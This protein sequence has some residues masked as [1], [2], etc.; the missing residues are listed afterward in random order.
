VWRAHSAG[1]FPNEFWDTSGS[2]PRVRIPVADL[3]SAG[4]TIGGSRATRPV[5]GLR[6][7]TARQHLGN[8]GAVVEWAMARGHLTHNPTRAVTALDP[9]P[10]IAV[11]PPDTAPVRVLYF[12]ECARVAAHLSIHHQV[13]YWIGRCCGLRVGEVFGLHV[14]DID[15]AGFLHVS[16]QGGGPMERWGPDGSR[17]KVYE[18]GVKSAAGIRVVPMPQSL[19]ALVELY[20]RAWH[21]DPTTG[22]LDP[23]ARLI[24]PPQPGRGTG[25]SS[26]THALTNALHAESL[27]RHSIGFTNLTHHLRKSLGGDLTHYGNARGFQ[28]SRLLGHKLGADGG[29]QI[30]VDHYAPPNPDD[31][32]P[33][34]VAMDTIEGLIGDALPDGLL[35]GTDAHAIAGPQIGMP[36]QQAHA[37]EVIADALASRAPAEVCTVAAAAEL[38]EV[39]PKQVRRL[40]ALGTLES[41]DAR[42]ATGRPVLAVTRRSVEAYAAEQRESC[43]LLEA[44]ELTGIG[45]STLYERMRVGTLLTHRGPDGRTPWVAW[46]EVK[47]LVEE[48]ELRAAL[49]DRSLTIPAAARAIGRHSSTVER[50]LAVGKLEADESASWTG[51]TYVTRASLAA[52]QEARGKDPAK[53]WATRT[54]VARLRPPAPNGP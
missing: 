39:T 19:L 36:E 47:L 41:A 16:H 31:V 28:V 21:A 23:Q 50:L 3:V 48:V 38:L 11:T 43:T 26:Y 37:R 17:I 9:D 27:D 20:L 13:C 35:Q 33:F 53:V 42:G 5:G 52:Y 8:L 49:D 4:F 29:S 54:R 30:T 1:R 15:P 44:A 51:F 7:A 45:Y 14:G 34:V 40:V 46:P 10:A 24:R 22:E 18:A 32:E 25:R 6:R 2:V 12:H